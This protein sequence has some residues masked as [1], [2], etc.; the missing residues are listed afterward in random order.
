[1][2]S[3]LTITDKLQCQIYIAQLK[4]DRINQPGII[5]EGIDKYVKSKNEKR[6][7][8]K[9][10]TKKKKIAKEEFYLPLF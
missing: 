2:P 9:K 1:M 6:Q 5:S 8:E 7:K 4:S 3:M 10:N